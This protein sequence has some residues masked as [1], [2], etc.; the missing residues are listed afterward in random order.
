MEGTISL[1]KLLAKSTV[2]YVLAA[3]IVQQTF[4]TPP[5]SHPAPALYS[6]LSHPRSPVMVAWQRVL[7][8]QRVRRLNA[9]FN[10]AACI[11]LMFEFYSPIRIDFSLIIM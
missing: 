5:H 4:C 10:M 8:T 2:N 11:G 6:S 7:F 9:R 3:F 1:I